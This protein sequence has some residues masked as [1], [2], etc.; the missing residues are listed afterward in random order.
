[1]ASGWWMHDLW[2]QSP[3]L[4]ASWVFWV[5]VS[6]MLHELAHGWAALWQGDDT[7][8]ALGH[9][10]FNPLVH[11][12]G[13]AL[14]FFVLVGFT[15]GLMPVNP[16]RFRMGRMGEVLVSAA[17]PAMNLLL[18]AITLTALGVWIARGPVGTPLFDNLRLFL[19]TGGWL[20]VFLAAFNMVP[21]PPLDGSKVLA[22]LV[23]P[24]RPLI[25]SP[26]LQQFGWIGIFLLGMLGFFGPVVALSQRW[27]AEWANLVA[28]RLLGG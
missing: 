19:F 22:G 9:M 7:P 11:M 5:L 14:L 18:A 15:W 1:M 28:Q 12:G 6:V 17:G 26:Q 20:N 25:E 3:V 2:Q 4:L 10:N 8:R 21:F 13:T 27:S 23:P 24:T 16:W